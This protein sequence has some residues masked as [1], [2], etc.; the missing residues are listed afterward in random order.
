MAGR[1][2]RKAAFAITAGKR[3]RKTHQKIKFRV[4]ETAETCVNTG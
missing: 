3:T 4:A 2:H 1:L